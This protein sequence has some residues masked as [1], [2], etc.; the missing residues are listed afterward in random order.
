MLKLDYKNV[1]RLR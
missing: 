1:G